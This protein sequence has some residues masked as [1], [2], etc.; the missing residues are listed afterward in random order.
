MRRA[1]FCLAAAA[2]LILIGV[3]LLAVGFAERRATKVR[4]QMFTLRHDTAARERSTVDDWVR[5]ARRLPWVAWIHAEMVEERATSQ[6]WL[7]EYESLAM[8]ADRSRAGSDI[9]PH[10]LMTAAHAAYRGTILD[11][12]DPGATKRLG[13]VLELYGEVLKRDPRDFDAAYNFEFVARRRNA[14]AL[15]RAAQSKSQGRARAAH[16]GSPR[17]GEG[18]SPHDASASRE[19]KT[20]G[21]AMPRAGKTL[22]GEQGAVPPGLEPE[23]FKVIVPSPSDEREEQ[24]DAGAGAPRIR[25]G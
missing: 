22:H 17:G 1:V 19:T 15:M 4:E 16:D 5:Y 18:R 20:R 3:S 8:Y 24:R 9:D 13:R 6:Y 21:A 10:L 12:S 25:K 23:E 7:R 2:L 14:L 11:G